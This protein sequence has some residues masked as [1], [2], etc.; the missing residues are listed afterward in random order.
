ME[1]T[2]N[3]NL[4]DDIPETFWAYLAG[5]IDGEGCVQLKKRFRK[6]DK[7]RGYT[8]ARQFTISNM[9]FRTIEW[10]RQTCQFGIINSHGRSGKYPYHSL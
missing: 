1:I 9:H 5:L 2:K 4:I 10:I 6:I 7:K 8:I 3:S